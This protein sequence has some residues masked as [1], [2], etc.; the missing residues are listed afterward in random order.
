M[1][2]SHLKQG[3]QDP[4]SS[5]LHYGQSITDACLSLEA[6]EPLLRML[7]ESVARSAQPSVSGSARD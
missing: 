7:A 6:T 1:I 2:E 4:A 3:Q 5:P